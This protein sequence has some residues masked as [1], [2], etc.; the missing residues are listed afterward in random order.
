GT[1]IVPFP[2]ESFLSGVQQKIDST[3]KLWYGKT[4][5]LKKVQGEQVL[6]H[7]GASDWE[8]IIYVN[9][10]TAGNFRSG[11]VPI[12]LNITE[13]LE[14]GKNELRLSCWDPTDKGAQGRGKQ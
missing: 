5:T 6:L 8:T 11:Y 7:I 3:K 9:G 4:I 2:L 10:K 12:V 14:T 1:I 13:F